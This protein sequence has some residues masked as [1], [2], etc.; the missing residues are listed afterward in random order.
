MHFF[1]QFKDHNPGRKHG[2]STNDP[3]FSSTIS[4]LTINNISEFEKAQNSLT[5]GSPFGSFW[6]V[7]YLNFW[8]KATD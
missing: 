4:T 2:N 8:P 7:K 3:I 1:R 5:C 6:P